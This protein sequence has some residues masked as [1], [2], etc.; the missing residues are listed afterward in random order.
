[1]PVAA[2]IYGS[3][4]RICLALG[5]NHLDDLAKEIEELITPP[6]P[7]GPRASD[8][9]VVGVCVVVISATASWRR[10]P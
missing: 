10:A 5:V 2:N 1:M 3:M 6:M 8:A 7:R 4:S 9:P